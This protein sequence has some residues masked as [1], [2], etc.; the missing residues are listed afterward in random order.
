MPGPG[1]SPARTRVH[2]ALTS[3]SEDDQ[4]RLGVIT[5]WK[6]GPHA[7]TDRQTERIF[8]LVT[9]VLAK[10]E[11]DGQPSRALQAFCDDLREASTMSQ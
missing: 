11:P 4:L 3:L 8:G 7:L 6:N 5:G 2:Q 10:D 1:R 9:G